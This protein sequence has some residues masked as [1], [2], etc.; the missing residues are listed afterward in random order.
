MVLPTCRQIEYTRLA[1]RGNGH[2]DIC[3]K[4]RPGSACTVRARKSE[5][6]LYDQI[7]FCAKVDLFNTENRG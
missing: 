7:R 3:V 6:A 1:T 2:S 4:C 5:T